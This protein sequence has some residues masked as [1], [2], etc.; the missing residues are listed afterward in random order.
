TRSKRDWSSDVCSSDLVPHGQRRPG[1]RRRGGSG[2]GRM[3]PARPAPVPVVV[4]GAGGMGRARISTVLGSEA[5]RLVGV[6]DVLDGAAALAVAEVVPAALRESVATGTDGVEVAQR[7]GAEAVIDVTIPAA[8][9]A[10]T[11]D[12]LHAGYPVLGEKP[13][14]ATLAEAVSLAGHAETT[15]T[16]FMISQSRRNNPHL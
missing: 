16:L 9:H 6:A 8:H 11:A 2:E 15:G 7:A 10:V 1:A 5:A 3:S 12:A 4:I 13:C 14:A